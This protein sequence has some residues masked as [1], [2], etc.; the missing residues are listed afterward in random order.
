MSFW[1]GVQLSNGFAFTVWYLVNNWDIF[2]LTMEFILEA[3][4]LV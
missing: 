1:R 3:G 4:V 2:T